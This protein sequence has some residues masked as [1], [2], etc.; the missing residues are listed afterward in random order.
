[1]TNEK[2]LD[3]VDAEVV[4]AENVTEEVE[5]AEESVVA[6]NYAIGLLIH[7]VKVKDGKEQVSHVYKPIL[8]E[9]EAKANALS[10]FNDPITAIEKAIDL[11]IDLKTRIEGIDFDLETS[12]LFN[13]KDKKSK[14]EKH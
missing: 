4:S 12:E 9:T 3:I 8:R 13:K 2:K 1:M 7:Q 11:L 14:E 5:T 10:L 6:N